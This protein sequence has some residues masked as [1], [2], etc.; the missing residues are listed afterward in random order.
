MYYTQ[1]Y[2]IEDTPNQILHMLSTLLLWS[3]T[4]YTTIGQYPTLYDFLAIAPKEIS[5]WNHYLTFPS[6][7]VKL[8]IFL[9]TLL[10]A[11]LYSHHM[12]D[13]GESQDVS[14]CHTITMTSPSICQLHDSSVCPPKC[15]STWNS[16]CPSVCPLS[17]LSVQPS[18]KIHSDNTHEY[19]CMKFPKHLNPRKIPFHLFII[20]FICQSI[21]QSICHLITIC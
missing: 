3:K 8:N 2:F 12:H 9:P 18:A 4:S 1:L 16:I 20:R 10:P 13:S 15:D 17:A 21:M 11:P 19:C 14:V 7:C 6:K 5:H